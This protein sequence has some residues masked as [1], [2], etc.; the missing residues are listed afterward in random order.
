MPHL[1]EAYVLLSKKKYNRIMIGRQTYINMSVEHI[2]MASRD[3][4]KT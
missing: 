2:T 1:H 3:E 4:K